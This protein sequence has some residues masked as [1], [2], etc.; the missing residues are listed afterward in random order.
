MT[1]KL[2]HYLAFVPLDAGFMIARGGGSIEN[3]II[4]QRLCF[5]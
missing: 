4:S 3:R 1:I 2:H 5:H